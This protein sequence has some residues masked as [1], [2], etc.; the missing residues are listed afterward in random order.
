[1]VAD[2]NGELI[3]IV[4]K[5]K[6]IPTKFSFNMASL[7]HAAE[8][9]VANGLLNFYTYLEISSEISQVWYSS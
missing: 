4:D 7:A 3:A 9:L 5:E 1:M 8:H 2:K 6:I